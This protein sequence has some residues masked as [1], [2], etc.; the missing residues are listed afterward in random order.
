MREWAEHVEMQ[1]KRE[2]PIPARSFRSEQGWEEKMCA[3]IKNEVNLKRH[4]QRNK[5]QTRR[6]KQKT[7]KRKQ[8]NT[9][10]QDVP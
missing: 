6:T 10:T 5:K 9:C 2:D 3:E 7:A 1:R 8:G 4:K